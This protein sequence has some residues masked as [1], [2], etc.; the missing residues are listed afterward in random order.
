MAVPSGT[1]AQAKAAGARFLLKNPKQHLLSRASFGAVTSIIPTSLAAFCSLVPIPT[2][3]PCCGRF[4]EAPSSWLRSWGCRLGDD[5]AGRL[6]GAEPLLPSLPSL[7]SPQPWHALRAAGCWPGGPARPNLLSAHTRG[8]LSSPSC[9]SQ[10]WPWPVGSRPESAACQLGKGSRA[11]RGGW[12][13]Q[14]P[15]T[16]L[17]LLL[18]RG[19]PSGGFC[20]FF[21]LVS[22]MPGLFCA[23]WVGGKSS[24]PYTLPCPT[25]SPPSFPLLPFPDQ[26]CLP[27]LYCKHYSALR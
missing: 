8:K 21:L 5:G 22:G 10:V 2:A 23:E 3:F 1:S 25:S 18:H 16:F 27:S 6:R 19:F 24:L 9:L 14:T 4:W 12:Q 7:P 20:F 26:S 17:G 11:S 13:H 15:Y